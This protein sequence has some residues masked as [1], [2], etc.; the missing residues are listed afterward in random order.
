MLAGLPVARPVPSDRLGPV[1][2][3]AVDSVETY[4]KGSVAAG[5]VREDGLLP[6][7]T[8]VFLPWLSALT[9]FVIR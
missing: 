8:R 4:C 7:V 5:L 9:L 6:V 1:R 2:G 3:K